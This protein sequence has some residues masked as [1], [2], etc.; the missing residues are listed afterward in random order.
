MRR[1]GVEREGGSII[2]WFAQGGGKGTREGTVKQFLGVRFEEVL[3]PK[4]KE[5]VLL[6]A[7]AVA[8]CKP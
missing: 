2:G 1:R 6:A 7:S 5:L 3:D 4:T 8:G